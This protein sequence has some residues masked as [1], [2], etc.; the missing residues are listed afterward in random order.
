MEQNQTEIK[1]RQVYITVENFNILLSIIHKVKQ[2]ISNEIENS[3]AIIQ[4]T[5]HLHNT[6]SFN[7]RIHRQVHTKYLPQQTIF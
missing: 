6:P 1:E 5:Q 4:F 7:S 2:K 3:N